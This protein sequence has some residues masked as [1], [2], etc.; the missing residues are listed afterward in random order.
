MVPKPFTAL[1]LIIHDACNGVHIII[2]TVRWAM[3]THACVSHA[4]EHTVDIKPS[5]YYSLVPI[6]LLKICS[7]Y[8][9]FTI[10]LRRFGSFTEL[11]Q[12]PS[13]VSCG[14]SKNNCEPKNDL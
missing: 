13:S 10:I 2:I 14:V 6:Y 8:P 4:F 9:G 11:F 5:E 7:H 1:C 3:L 12:L